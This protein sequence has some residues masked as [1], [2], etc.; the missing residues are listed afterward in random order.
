[1]RIYVF[2]TRTIDYPGERASD[3]HCGNGGIDESISRNRNYFFEKADGFMF[4]EKAS[5]RAKSVDASKRP[6]F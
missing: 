4:G 3:R 1:M 5:F 2:P 6:F